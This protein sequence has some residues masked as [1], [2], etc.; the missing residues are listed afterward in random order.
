MY[1]LGVHAPFGVH[2]IPAVFV[3]P[4]CGW[5]H[6]FLVG[7]RSGPT[8]GDF[9]CGGLGGVLRC[10]EWHSVRVVF[11]CFRTA[12]AP[13]CVCF[14]DGVARFLMLLNHVCHCEWRDVMRFDVD[15]WFWCNPCCVHQM[16]CDSQRTLFLCCCMSTSLHIADCCFA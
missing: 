16:V 9:G 15:G 10:E 7:G 11:I 13:H 3:V 12:C 2:F 5:D 4:K 1:Q 6:T 8:F 14:A